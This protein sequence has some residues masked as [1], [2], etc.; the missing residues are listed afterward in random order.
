V[1]QARTPET[2]AQSLPETAAQSLPETAAHPDRQALLPHKAEQAPRQAEPAASRPVEIH[3][4]E[5]RPDLQES[6]ESLVSAAQ[7]ASRVK[8]AR[9][10][11]E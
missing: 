11:R 8:A 1:R 3:Q 9:E 7:R 5:D 2:A 6:A 10:E 4:P